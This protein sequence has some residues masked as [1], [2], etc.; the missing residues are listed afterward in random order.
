MWR[1]WFVQDSTMCCY[2][3]CCVCVCVVWYLWLTVLCVFLEGCVPRWAQRYGVTFDLTIVI[4]RRQD[5]FLLWTPTTHLALATLL[6]YPHH[7]CAL[8]IVH[9]LNKQ[10][11]GYLFDFL[12]GSYS[13]SSRLSEP[14]R[15]MFGIYRFGKE[16]DALLNGYDTETQS[17]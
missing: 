12:I 6:P 13:K 1:N 10:S 2:S 9:V 17:L 3:P 4:K 15:L 5:H 8:I 14:T 16:C 11:L 7:C